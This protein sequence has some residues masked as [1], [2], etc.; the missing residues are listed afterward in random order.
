VK[1]YGVRGSRTLAS[2]TI[3]A[4]NILVCRAYCHKI[5]KLSAT[6]PVL[7][8]YKE[9]VCNV[10]GVRD[11]FLSKDPS[12]LNM[13]L[14][15]SQNSSTSIYFIGKILWAKG[16]NFLL[17]CQE[18]YKEEHGEYFPIDVYGGGPDFDSIKRA[19]YGVN[20]RGKTEN[21]S[22]NTLPDKVENDTE[23]EEEDSVSD[24][25]GESLGDLEEEEEDEDSFFTRLSKA[26]KP[27]LEKHQMKE[28]DIDCDEVDDEAVASQE[29]MSTLRTI[30]D[31]MKLIKNFPT[32]TFHF[33]KIPRNRHEWRR[34][35]IPAR[36]LGPKDHSLLKNSQYKIFVN[37][38]ITEVLCTTSAEALAMGFFVI[39]PRHKSNEFFYQFPNCLAYS[40][41][42]QFVSHL[43]YALSNDPTPLTDELSYQFTWEAA[44]NRLFQSATV[45]KKEYN[46]LL[47][48]GRIKRDIR[49]AWI[50]K[51]SGRVIKGDVLR[52]LVGEPPREKL[53]QYEVDGNGDAD[54]YNSNV[55]SFENKNPKFLVFLSFLIAITSYFFQR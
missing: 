15:K 34:E 26:M 49:K 7:A 16:F 21:K 30:K 9:C 41:M 36:F 55:L 37:P 31:S 45:T 12:E 53:S 3:H 11:E 47:E 39:L 20:S 8:R 54:D 35:A 14:D 5:I 52:S 32:K 4:L 42:A 1:D 51:E 24:E 50:H 40:D 33:D 2:K 46:R 17:H 22:G 23:H 19:F 6:L 28:D 18:K 27:Y 13:S 38:S 29:K 44:M 43:N 10:H 25:S 48:S